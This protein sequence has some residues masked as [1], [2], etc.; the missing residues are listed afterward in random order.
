ML[1]ARFEPERVY[2][3]AFDKGSGQPLEPM[4]Q[5]MA[6]VMPIALRKLYEDRLWKYGPP[7]DVEM[8]ELCGTGHVKRARQVRRILKKR[9]NG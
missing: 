4:Q 3:V 2:V 6:G 8:V 5:V 1:D 9:L 7:G